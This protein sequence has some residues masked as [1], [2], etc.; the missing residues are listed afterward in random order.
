M[1]SDIH[2]KNSVNSVDHL[3][4]LS[5]YRAKPYLDMEGVTTIPKGSRDQV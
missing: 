4:K 1:Y 5:Q 2:I 3:D